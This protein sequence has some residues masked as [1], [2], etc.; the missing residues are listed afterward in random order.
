LSSKD[1][2][3][4]YYQ[5][6]NQP[7]YSKSLYSFFNEIVLAK[8]PSHELKILELGGGSFSLFEDFSDLKAEI[9]SIDFS[10]EAI[11]KAPQS[12]INYLEADISNSSYFN[13]AKYD[14]I[15]D[16]HCLNCITGS[17]QRDL[18]FKNIYGSL[19]EGGIFTSELMVQPSGEKV[20][21]P[22]K[23]IKTVRE[24]EEE[25]LSYGFRILSFMV[26][27]SEHFETVV[28][29]VEVKCDLLRVVVGK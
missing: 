19:K 15:F 23:V 3:D 28:D 6:H 17:D 7:Y 14:L 27:R 16:S 25:I 1:F 20:F 5:A 9:T 29:G 10:S 2:F 13:E 11:A 26:S 22:L 4:R 24:F 18:A 21:M 8:L 12:K